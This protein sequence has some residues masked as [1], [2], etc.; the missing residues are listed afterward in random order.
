MAY[1]IN[2]L[3][4]MWQDI[5]SHSDLRAKP[6]AS[7]MCARINSHTYD[8]SIYRKECHIFIT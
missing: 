6:D 7:Q 2:V 8:D 3:R 5:M 1:V 4:S